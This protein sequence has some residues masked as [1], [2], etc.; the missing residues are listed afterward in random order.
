[1]T[2]DRADGFVVT[3]RPVRGEPRREVYAPLAAG[4]FERREERWTGCKWV[5]VG[6]ERLE[7]LEVENAG[8]V[9]R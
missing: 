8:V 2:R 6:T 7:T 5:V 9:Q 3:R 4:G 1:M